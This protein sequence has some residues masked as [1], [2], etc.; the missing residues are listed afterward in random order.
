MGFFSGLD[1]LLCYL[2]GTQAKMVGRR[3]LE[4]SSSFIYIP[5]GSIIL[6]IFAI[7]FGICKWLGRADAEVEQTHQPEPLDVERAPAPSRAECSAATSYPQFASSTS[8][9]PGVVQVPA[10]DFAGYS[11]ERNPFTRAQI[12]AMTIDELKTLKEKLNMG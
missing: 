9:S 4:S 8:Y 11:P 5:V 7:V 3:L 12:E 1:W 10:V 6:L 2:I